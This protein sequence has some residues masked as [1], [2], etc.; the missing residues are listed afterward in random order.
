MLGVIAAV[1]ASSVR[2][3]SSTI[4]IAVLL[5]SLFGIISST[6]FDIIRISTA[7]K[8]AVGWAS[9]ILDGF[10]T[11][12]SA[13]MAQIF[14][15]V[16]TS[17]FDVAIYVFIYVVVFIAFVWGVSRNSFLKLLA[18]K[19]K[20]ISRRMGR[21]TTVSLLIGLLVIASWNTR[22]QRNIN[23]KEVYGDV[24]EYIATH[25][26][27]NETLGYL[28]SYRSYFFYGKH[29]N[30]KVLYVPSKSENLSHWLDDLKQRQISFIA[31]G[32]LED[33]MGLKP[34]EVLW[35]KSSDEQ[36]TSVFGKDPKKGVTIYRF[37]RG[38]GF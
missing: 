2:I 13:S 8:G 7:F 3:H 17:L 31:V 1:V 11:N 22:E 34:R 27:P 12:P 33:K 29:W 38:K 19:A 36:F 37:Q 32:P 4:A 30:Q 14:E 28:L 18:T 16:G 10:R 26:N 23:R 15:I 35:L 5:S 6:V 25:L 21:F 24:Y 20:Q 9:A